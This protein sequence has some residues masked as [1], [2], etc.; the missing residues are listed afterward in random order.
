MSNSTYSRESLVFQFLSSQEFA[1]LLTEKN[2]DP[3]I[4][5][6]LLSAHLV[7]IGFNTTGISEGGATVKYFRKLSPKEDFLR[8]ESNF[9]FYT[10]TYKL[11]EESNRC[12]RSRLSLKNKIFSCK[13]TIDFRNFCVE[14][15]NKYSKTVNKDITNVFIDETK[16]SFRLDRENR[17]SDKA[18]SEAYQTVIASNNIIKNHVEA[19]YLDKKLGVNKYLEPAKKIKL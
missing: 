16:I 9:Y 1:E 19:W 12:S 3:E 18:Q 5:N 4:N 6:L 2:L 13:Y 15:Y 17:K 11:I 7:A 14:Y 8:P 10:T